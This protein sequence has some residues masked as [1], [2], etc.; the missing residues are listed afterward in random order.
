MFI[1]FPASHGVGSL[2]PRSGDVP[3][4]WFSKLAPGIVSYWESMGDLFI[5][6]LQSSMAYA[7]PVATLSNSKQGSGETLYDYFRRFNAEVPYVRGDIDEAVKNFLIA[8]LKRGSD[9]WKNIQAHEPATLQDFY[10]QGEPYKIVEKSMAELDNWSPPPRDNYRYKNIKRGRS[11]TPEKKR[12][13][14]SPKKERFK[15]EKTPP[16]SNTRTQGR[17]QNKFTP[18]VASIDH[19]YASNA[20]KGIFKKPATSRLGMILETVGS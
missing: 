6:Q 17:G 12:W 13:S 7:P 14:P 20:D 5:R 19:I 15:K 10:R 1:R 2:L 9:F 11:V 18:L 4:S 16:K 8:G 3:N